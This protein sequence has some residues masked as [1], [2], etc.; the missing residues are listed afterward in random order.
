[1][2]VLASL[3]QVHFLGVAR[4]RLSVLRVGPVVES[5]VAT[6]LVVWEHLEVAALTVQQGP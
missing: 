6:Q 3:W 1:M 2:N 4:W 5:D